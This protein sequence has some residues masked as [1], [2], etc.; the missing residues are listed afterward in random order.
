MA[1]LPSWI[2]YWFT[3]N[4]L[5]FSYSLLLLVFY[6]FVF[7]NFRIPPAYQE[8]LEWIYLEQ[9]YAQVPL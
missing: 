1:P 3:L 2:R 6:L 7:L 8:A 5:G 9:K 4:I